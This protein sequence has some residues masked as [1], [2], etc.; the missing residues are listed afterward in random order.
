[1][2]VIL[3]LKRIEAGRSRV[4]GLPLFPGKFE[5]SLS[6]LFGVF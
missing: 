6:L 2:S 5:A 1:M 3:A 4:Q